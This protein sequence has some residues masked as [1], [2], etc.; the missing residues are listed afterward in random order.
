MFSSTERKFE[1]HTINLVVS[2]KNEK[3]TKNKVVFCYIFLKNKLSFT[4]FASYHV[5][6]W[7]YLM[8]T[9]QYEQ[10]S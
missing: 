10:I 2:L 3:R 1:R 4:L 9:R 5:S 8:K 7:K 6:L